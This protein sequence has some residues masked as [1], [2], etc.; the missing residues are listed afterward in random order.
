MSTMPIAAQ[1]AGAREPMWLEVDDLVQRYK[2]PREHLFRPAPQL[3]ALN[4]VSLQLA[5]GK[6][7]GVVGESGSG[8]STLSGVVMAL[9]T[10]T[11]GSVRLLG[12][13]LQ[14]LSARDLRLARRDIQMVFQD[15]YGSLDPLHTVARIVAE[16]MTALG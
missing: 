2:L 5:A 4:G 8:K 16:P 1:A 14:R 7:L 3:L 11:L 10:P 12:R 15:P 6:I 13:V 9:E